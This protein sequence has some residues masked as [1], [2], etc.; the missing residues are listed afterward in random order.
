MSAR[1]GRPF[2]QAQGR[3]DSYQPLSR[4]AASRPGLHAVHVGEGDR[5]A[6]QLGAGQVGKTF[7]I[8][9]SAEREKTWGEVANAVGGIARIHDAQGSSREALAW[10][11]SLG[12]SQLVSQS[13]KTFGGFTDIPADAGAFQALDRHLKRRGRGTRGLEG[14]WRGACYRWCPVMWFPVL[15]VIG[16]CAGW[17]GR[18]R[19]TNNAQR[20]GNGASEVTVQPHSFSAWCPYLGQMGIRASQPQ[21]FRVGQGFWPPTAVPGSTT[22]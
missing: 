4:R 1:L 9:P 14:V 5:L 2:D 13:P 7:P 6:A 18:M 16:P 17:N 19:S 20:S 3:P 12:E 15:V 10:N 21:G 22:R 8:R 11:R